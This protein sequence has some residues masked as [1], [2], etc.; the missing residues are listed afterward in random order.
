MN[1]PAEKTIEE[2]IDQI[3]ETRDKYI[4]IAEEIG[5]AYNNSILI[6]DFFIY[7]GIER[8]LDI[9]DSFLLLLKE[10]HFQSAGAL[11]R[12][13]LDTLLRLYALTMVKSKQEFVTAIM[14]G[15][16]MDKLVDVNGKKLTD[17]YLRECFF[18]AP[19]N[20]NWI[21]LNEIYTETSGFIH[22]SSKHI[23]APLKK[24]EENTLSF[25]LG[26]RLDI[27]E[28]SKREILG[29]FLMITNA[30]LA[31]L[32]GWKELKESYENR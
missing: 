22:F 9:T 1:K 16:H 15:T 30:H 23:Y 12:M 25:E 5:K 28:K 7:G 32:Y 17:A 31:Y 24:M 27:P 4:E 2:M 8:A 13:H 20:K 11:L 26:S 3:E 29:A 14:E 10:D 18:S 19:E 6:S 21:S